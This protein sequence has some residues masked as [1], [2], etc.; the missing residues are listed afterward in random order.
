MPTFQI[1]N[2]G[3]R[4]NQADGASL[5]DELASRGLRAAGCGRADIVVLNSCT[6]TAAADYS[7]RQ[8]VRKVKRQNPEAQILVTGCYAQRRPEEIAAL[9]GVS[10]VVGNSHKAQIA[11]LLSQECVRATGSCES[12]QFVPLEA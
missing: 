10:F 11:G 2:F 1:M 8:A 5:H 7:L 12:A 3:C 4:A 9:P 6:V